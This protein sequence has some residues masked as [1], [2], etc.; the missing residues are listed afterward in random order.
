VVARAEE[1]LATLERASRLGALTRLAD[2][3]PLFAATA[4][5]AAAPVVKAS[6]AEAALKDINPDELTPRAA[7][8]L[9]YRLKALAE[10]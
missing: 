4:A 1:V 9:L 8:E 7:L 10:S 5:K 2:D 6:A 3:L